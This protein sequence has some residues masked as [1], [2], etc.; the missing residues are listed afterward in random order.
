MFYCSRTLPNTFALGLVNLAFS[1]WLQDR[2]TETFAIFAVS[3]AFFR[4]QVAH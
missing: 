1:Y 2:Y 4:Q 3:I